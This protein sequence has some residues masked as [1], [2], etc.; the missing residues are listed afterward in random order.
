[1]IYFADTAH[2]PYGVR[3]AEF[4][5]D[6]SL[7]VTRSMIDRG[8]KLLVVACNTASAVALE[9]IRAIAPFEVVGLE[10]AVKPAVELTRTGRIAVFATPRTIE[11]HR[12]SRLVER[13][14]QSI[15]VERVA[16][17]GWVELVESGDAMQQSTIDLLRPVVVPPHD[18]GADVFVLGCTHYP[19]LAPALREIFGSEVTFVESGS[20]ISRRTKQLLTRDHLLYPDDSNEGRFTMLTSSPD[21]GR[22]QRTA[23]M[24]LGERAR[25]VAAHV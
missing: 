10:P 1:M 22:V 15:E 19:F 12:F 16:V 18:R 25:V 14:A 8:I 13:H 11:S 9:A 3:D 23:T 6:R 20:A 2:C 24:L 21:T 4:I 5:V 17:T 7:A